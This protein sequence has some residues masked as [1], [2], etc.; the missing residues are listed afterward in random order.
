MLFDH[1]NVLFLHLHTFKSKTHAL[2][3]LKSFAYK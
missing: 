3:S 1:L 2:G